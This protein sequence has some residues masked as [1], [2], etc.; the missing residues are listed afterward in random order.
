MVETCCVHAAA[1][2]SKVLRGQIKWPSIKPPGHD[3]VPIA[4]SQ[5]DQK[6]TYTSVI[7]QDGHLHRF[8]GITGSGMANDFEH[9]ERAQCAKQHVLLLLAQSVCLR[10]QLGC[11]ALWRTLQVQQMLSEAAP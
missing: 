7:M 8:T 4:A 9:P 11:I 2:P 5:D 6:C 3:G 1:Q 10:S